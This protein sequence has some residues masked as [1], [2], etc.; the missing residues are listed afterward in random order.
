[1]EI[2]NELLG[3]PK[4][5]IYQSTEHLHF[6]LDS[7]LLAHFVSTG[8]KVKNIVDLGTG[9]APIPL[10]LSLKTNAK[11]YGVEVQESSAQ[12]ARK[13]I[14]INNL[15]DQIE[16]VEANLI[17]VNKTIGRNFDVVVCNP[18]FFKVT[19]N[20]NINKNEFLTIA[21]HEVL[22]TLEDIIKEA[23]SLL[24]YSGAFYLVHRPC[25]L[26]EILTL[27]SAY[28]FQVSKLQFVYPKPN[29]KSNHVLIEAKKTTNVCQ[30]KVLEPLI[31]R[32][33]NN[34]LTDIVKDIY[35]GKLD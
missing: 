28:S 23:S 31:V 29:T 10:Y 1:M 22:A 7:I 17:G 2:L 30:T 26:Q 5:K 3:I 34:M 4:I 12:L 13:S 6:T 33:D 8:N 15:E 21:R 11:I 9:N 27:L 20:S 16:I 18:P 32:D 14:K 35:N 25:R 19:P 24:K